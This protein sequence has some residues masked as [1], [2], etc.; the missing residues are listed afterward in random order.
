MTLIGQVRRTIFGIPVEE[1]TV[2]RR[3]FHTSDSRVAERLERI[4]MEFLSG[5]HMAMEEPMAGPLAARL[6]GAVSLQ[7]RGFVFE[8]AAMGL[9]LLDRVGLSRRAFASFL[10]G[11]GQPHIYMLHIGAGWAVARLPWLRLRWP[12]VLASFDPLL[13]WLVV[14]GWGFHEGYFHWPAAIRR[15]TLPRGLSGYA[16]RAFDQGLGRSLWFVDGIDLDRIAS[17]ISG[18][19]AHRHNDLWAGVGL[20]CAYAGGANPLALADLAALAGVHA[21]AAAQGAAFAAEARHRARNPAADCDLACRGLCGISADAAAAIARET[22]MN[23]PP[24]GAI[25]GYEVWRARLQQHF[26]RA[27]QGV[28]Q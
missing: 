17:S 2:A 20:G 23:L 15:H 24:D 19:P 6:N 12:A 4:G 13:R 25:P 16:A 11:P 18:F 26:L 27:P 14:D 7:D 28:C 5:Y 3:G 1:A 21:P 8:G 10:K 9:F 22:R